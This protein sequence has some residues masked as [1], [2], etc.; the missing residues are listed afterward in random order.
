MLEKNGLTSLE[1]R[2]EF[3]YKK[4][5]HL[6]TRRR[7]FRTE[8][9]IWGCSVSWLKPGA[10]QSILLR[11]LICKHSGPHL[12]ILCRKMCSSACT[13]KKNLWK[14]HIWPI[15]VDNS[16]G[17]DKCGSWNRSS[18]TCYALKY[19]RIRGFTHWSKTL[20]REI[21]KRI[22]NKTCLCSTFDTR[23][24]QCHNVNDAFIGSSIFSYIKGYIRCP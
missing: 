20:R 19:S 18:L 14:F 10:V 13:Y 4:D 24:T 15:P 6:Y 1:G 9:S 11:E 21:W 16:E 8:D 7:N 12:S 5:E 3:D 22:S 2:G 23:H 17:L